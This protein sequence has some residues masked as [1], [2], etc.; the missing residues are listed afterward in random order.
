MKAE[1]IRTQKAPAPAGAYSQAVRIGQLVFTAQVGPMDPETNQ[2]VA[3]GDMAAQTRK[4]LE[5]I[6]AILEAAGAT[7]ENVVKVTA[8]IET[9]RWKEFNAVYA[10]FFSEAVFP[11]RSIVARPKGGG[12]VVSMDAI[13][14]V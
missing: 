3:P 14:H 9:E 13:A 10:E 7:L 11:A 8:Y 4:T 2:V 6:Q 5:N 12:Q 1:A